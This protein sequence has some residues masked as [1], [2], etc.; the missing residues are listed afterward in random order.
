M[1]H[2]TAKS[3]LILTER[4]LQILAMVYL[5]DGVVVEQLRR[6]FWGRF[7]ARS[8]CFSRVAKL[9]QAAY[10]KGVRLP[11]ASW[12]GSGKLFVTIGPA[13]RPVLG[14]LL[15]LTRAE[16]ER[17]TRMGAPRVVG[18]HLAIGDFRLSVELAAA[19]LPN[20]EPLEWVTEVVLA[21]TPIE[22]EVPSST[23]PV[24][25]AQ[26]LRIIPDGE[27]TLSTPRGTLTAYLE[28]DMGTIPL[29]LRHKLAGY[30]QHQ[31]TLPHPRPILFVTTTSQRQATLAEW[32]S[33]A[34]RALGADPTVFLFTTMERV[35]EATVFAAPIWRVAGGP[36][37]QA[38][39]PALH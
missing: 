30:L 12:C 5:Y 17:A 16:L 26:S 7:G 21:R 19:A 11:P 3:S 18:H 36:T 39:L 38:L 9:L 29:R 13:A 25:K 8:A 31:R 33:Q 24:E 27:F 15:E 22:V 37:A 10:L 35:S 28:L 6:R 20:A 23:R 4:D 34:A 1:S 14:Q 2:A 32:A